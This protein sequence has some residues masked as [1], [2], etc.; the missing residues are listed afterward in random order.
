MEWNTGM[1]ECFRGHTLSRSSSTLFRIDGMGIY[2]NLRFR[3]LTHVP[4]SIRIAWVLNLCNNCTNSDAGI[5]SMHQCDAVK[6]GC[7]SFVLNIIMKKKLLLQKI[8]VHKRRR[9]Q[10]ICRYVT[11]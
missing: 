7:S 8:G 3:L 6:G 2:W 4:T 5:Y 9:D 10:V 11:Q 1:V